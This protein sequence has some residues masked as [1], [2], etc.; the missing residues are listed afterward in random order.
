MLAG[1][2]SAISWVR[3][4][5]IGV[6]IKCNRRLYSYILERRRT[7]GERASLIAIDVPPDRSTFASIGELFGVATVR[8]CDHA[9]R[10]KYV[11]VTCLAFS[12]TSIRHQGLAISGNSTEAASILAGSMSASVI[13]ILQGQQLLRAYNYIA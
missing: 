8:D 1:R 11:R 9:Y 3:C 2:H 10:P 6:G 7:T 5:D 12:H 13:R 4:N